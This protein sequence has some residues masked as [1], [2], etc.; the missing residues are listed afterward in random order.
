[1]GESFRDVGATTHAEK[2]KGSGARVDDSSAFVSQAR[3]ASA[4]LDPAEQ[5]A[6]YFAEWFGRPFAAEGAKRG[7]DFRERRMGQVGFAIILGLKILKVGEGL[8]KYPE[9]R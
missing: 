6:C 9:L 2:A 5:I 7:I 1:V 8:V 4:V 3:E